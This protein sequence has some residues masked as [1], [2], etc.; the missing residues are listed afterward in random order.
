MMSGQQKPSAVW[1]HQTEELAQELVG[2][3]ADGLHHRFLGWAEGGLLQGRLFFLD[4]VARPDDAPAFEIRIREI[5]CG[6]LRE[7]IREG[8]NQRLK[9]GLS[10]AE[11]DIQIGRVLVHGMVPTLLWS[12]TEAYRPVY[13]FFNMDTKC[14]VH[15]DCLACIRED[16]IRRDPL[17][18]KVVPPLWK[19]TLRRELQDAQLDPDLTPACWKNVFLAQ[20]DLVECQW[21]NPGGGPQQ[22]FGRWTLQDI[23]ILSRLRLIKWAIRKR[24]V[25]RTPGLSMSEKP[26]EL[27]LL[28]PVYFDIAEIPKGETLNVVSVTKWAQ[29]ELRTFAEARRRGQAEEA[30]SALQDPMRQYVN[31]FEC[32]GW[33]EASVWESPWKAKREGPAEDKD[34]WDCS[35]QVTLARDLWTKADKDNPLW[36]SDQAVPVL[37]LNTQRCAL[38]VGDNEAP[39]QAIYGC[40]TLDDHVCIYFE[41]EFRNQAKAISDLA[42]KEPTPGQLKLTDSTENPLRSIRRLKDFCLRVLAPC[43]R[44]FRL[45]DARWENHRALELVLPPDTQRKILIPPAE[46]EERMSASGKASSRSFTERL[47]LAKYHYMKR[48]YVEEDRPVNL[49][50]ASMGDIWKF[51]FAEAVKPQYSDFQRFQ[52]LLKDMPSYRD[53]LTHSI[54]V[55]LL[56]EKIIEAF[57]HSLHLVDR[58][59]KGTYPDIQFNDDDVVMLRGTE[60]AILR[61]QWALA[62]L[63]HDFACPAES[64]DYVVDHLFRTFLGVSARGN[65]GRNGLH[66]ALKQDE[67]RHR[68]FLY[69]LLSRTQMGSMCIPTWRKKCGEW[70]RLLDGLDA[71]P[72]LSEFAYERLSEDHGFLSAV[73]LFSELFEKSD[74]SEP[75]WWRLKKPFVDLICA[76]LFGPGNDT[77]VREQRDGTG[78][79]YVRLA[80]ALMLEVLDAIV[81]HNACA[82]EYRLF[83][84]QRP[85]YRFPSTGFTAGSSIFASPIP[86]LLLLCDTVCD[87]GRVVH[88]DQLRGDELKAGSRWELPEISRPEGRLTCPKEESDAGGP[89]KIEVRYEWRLPYSRPGIERAPEWCLAKIYDQ[90]Q[91]AMAPYTPGFR[92]WKGCETCM[93]GR[94][95]DD[96][97]DVKEC[98]AFK[99]LRRFWQ[100]VLFGARTGDNRLAFPADFY[101]SDL[102]QIHLAAS[103]GRVWCLE[104]RC[105]GD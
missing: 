56:G 74:S 44:A 83:S 50:L 21:L 75:S 16:N 62:S 25:V 51:V 59:Q 90:L 49:A 13:F 11:D 7:V 105:V 70:F 98:A 38:M 47:D 85:A 30:A 79:A 96:V 15:R 10:I 19:W 8:V 100:E 91:K 71:L 72:I 84:L 24:P 58:L 101:R 33:E 14:A 36:N 31:T 43:Q 34:K 1:E 52:Q 35:G 29:R 32:E 80:E 37:A 18:D 20:P 67:S 87:Y 102:N 97:Q 22:Q 95:V 5:L 45:A 68:A 86:G 103:F 89:L 66:D 55:F 26:S 99:N 4:E 88:P 63:M 76:V 6:L 77:A 94:K 28:L 48:V 60:Q 9:G 73:Y 82:K 104:D 3:G 41:L 54:Q 42:A 69:G 65:A 64:A 12:R 39:V 78:S 93:K 92:P 46:L 57:P 53:H 27:S 2:P 17:L 40:P 23:L 81:R 61:F